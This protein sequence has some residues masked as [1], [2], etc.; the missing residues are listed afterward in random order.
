MDIDAYAATHRGDWDRLAY[1]SRT[2]RP[3]NGAEADE[4]VAL[5][6]RVATH[7]SVIRSAAPDATVVGHLSSVLATAR[8]AI[9]GP[10]VP[11]WREVLHFFTD[12]FP[13]AVYRARRWWI[14][15]AL[16]SIAAAVLMGWY[17]YANPRVQT[18]L[19]TPDQIQA[20]TKPGGEFESYYTDFSPGSFGFQV[21][22]NN[23]WVAALTLF[24][25]VTLGIFTLGGLYE[26]VVNVGVQGGLMAAH[27]RLGT[28]LSLIAPHGMLELTAI[29]IAG[30]CGLRIAWAILSPGPRTRAE[31]LAEQ[32]RVLATLAMGLAC[33]LLISGAIEGFVTG[34][35]SP[36]VRLTI[37]AVAE[38]LF[39]T[40]VF[41]VG[42][43][44]AARGER[45]DVSA[46]DRG[47]SL[48]A[49]A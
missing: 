30:G 15:T 20:L 14:S 42:R 48:P 8:G 33:V 9:A 47:D 24:G 29:F 45:G 32:G 37:G 10:R 18:E 31:A 7:L 16:V 44:A 2:S 46:A 26:N 22:I 25:G 40:Y 36:P 41:V 6:Q 43:R 21:W 23:S 28:F 27:G 39:V 12:G 17:V 35:T 3:L 34:Y 1:L 38:I 13:A 11:A 49:R 5:Y 4:L 19:I